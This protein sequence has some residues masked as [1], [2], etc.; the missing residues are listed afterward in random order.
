MSMLICAS[1]MAHTNESTFET[2]QVLPNG[3]PGTMVGPGDNAKSKLPTV[4]QVSTLSAIM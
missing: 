1:M 2:R 4:L 3:T